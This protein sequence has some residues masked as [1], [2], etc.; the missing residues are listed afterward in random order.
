MTLTS[1]ERGWI[2]NDSTKV[3][4]QPKILKYNLLPEGEGYSPKRYKADKTESK[5]AIDFMVK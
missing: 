3:L 2:V 4:T 5:Y 1:T